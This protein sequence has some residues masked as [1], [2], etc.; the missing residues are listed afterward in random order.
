[1]V[2]FA[3]SISNVPLIEWTERSLKLIVK[4]RQNPLRAARCLS[5]L[6]VVMHD[7]LWIAQHLPYSIREAVVHRAA[8]QT[9]AYFFPYEVH[10]HRTTLDD[11]TPDKFK[12]GKDNG[13]PTIVA[14]LAARVFNAA[15]SRAWRDGSEREWTPQQLP[16]LGQGQWRPSPPLRIATPMEALAGEW[17]TWGLGVDAPQAPEPLRGD[18]AIAELEEVRRIRKS[19]SHEQ[20][21]LAERW[22]LDRGTVTPAG[23]WNRIALEM[24]PA[25]QRGT[26]HA[27]AELALLN[28]VMM[29]ALI[30]CWRA[31]YRW[32]TERPITAIRSLGDPHFTSWLLTPPFPSY[33]S[34]HATVSGAAARVLGWLMPEQRATLE[35]MAE[36]AAWSRLLG[37]IH[38]R[39]DNEAGLALGRAVADSITTRYTRAE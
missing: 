31:K 21:A 36:E 2:E 35:A 15:L 27:V 18:Q 37:G 7:A 10:E 16:R 30:V 22:N 39:N 11:G 24:L 17:Q 38:T 3:P 5:Y 9:I 25:R 1:M 29:D 19:L 34:G 33:V 12:A 20:K 6:H 13:A 32:W 14:T 28:V 26:E 23:V 8:A 4:Y